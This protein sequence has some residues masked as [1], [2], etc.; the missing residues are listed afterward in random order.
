MVAQTQK[1]EP[2]LRQLLGI[3][4][5]ETV[6]WE[7]LRGLWDNHYVATTNLQHSGSNTLFAACIA[8]QLLALAAPK[9]FLPA[10]TT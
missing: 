7:F 3:L 10:A 5:C 8:T 1:P 2:L 6:L 9:L 4:W